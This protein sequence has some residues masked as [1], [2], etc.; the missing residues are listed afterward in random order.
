V[1]HVVKQYIWCRDHNRIVL[2]CTL[3]KTI[4]VYLRG[5]LNLLDKMV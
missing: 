1:H 4:C 3:W 2:K 5:K